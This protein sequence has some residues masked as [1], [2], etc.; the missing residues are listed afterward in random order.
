MKMLDFFLVSQGLKLGT[1]HSAR[2]H[3]LNQVIVRMI[4]FIAL[5]LCLSRESVWEIRGERPTST[6]A[7]PSY[8]SSVQ[9][10]KCLLAFGKGLYFPCAKQ[11]H[12]RGN[13]SL[14]Q[15]SIAIII[16]FYMYREFLS[17]KHFSSI[18]S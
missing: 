3:D 16:I 17:L 5:S 14:W 15:D 8:F 4:S 7:T 11:L 6:T 12:S 2:R 9:A 13:I 10:S 1:N 18:I